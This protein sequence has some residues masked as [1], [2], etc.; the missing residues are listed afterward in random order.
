MEEN[1]F[2]N[3][4][5]FDCHC[6]LKHNGFIVRDEKKDEIDQKRY[7]TRNEIDQKECTNKNKFSR[8]K[9]TPTHL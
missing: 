6:D 7:I 4:S 1:F 3:V 2:F 9:H 5:L 8:V